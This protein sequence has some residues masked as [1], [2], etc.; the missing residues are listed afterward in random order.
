MTDE[1]Q[2]ANPTTEA[3]NRA[4]A[5]MRETSFVRLTV[6]SALAIDRGQEFEV[7]LLAYE[8]APVGLMPDPEGPIGNL[9]G[10]YTLKFSVVE[11]AKV[12]ISHPSA[13]N[14]AMNI[15]HQ[16]MKAG[17]MQREGFEKAIQDM[18]SGSEFVDEGTKS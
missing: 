16:S 12:R 17:Q 11:V 14:L 1:G 8:R 5:I 9:D 2:S 6:D 3:D 13:I 4:L 15:L 10:E 18:L 7:S